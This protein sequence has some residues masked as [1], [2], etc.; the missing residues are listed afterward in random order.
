MSAMMAP[1]V[2]PMTSWEA[3]CPGS[4]A[5]C[6]RSRTST[7]AMTT[8]ERRVLQLD[9]LTLCSRASDLL[10]AAPP[11][12]I[13]PLFQQRGPTRKAGPHADYTWLN[14]KGPLHRRPGR[15]RTRRRRRSVRRAR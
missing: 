3:N 13:G 10:L 6:D 7:T 11:V 9:D 12:V 8:A 2:T 5:A 1:L 4:W 14:L 15:A